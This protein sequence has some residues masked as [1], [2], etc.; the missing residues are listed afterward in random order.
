MRNVVGNR[1]LKGALPAAGDTYILKFGGVDAPL[2]TGSAGS[3]Y[4]MVQNVPKVI[5]GPN[6]SALV[7]LWLPA[8]S[9]A[10]SYLP[11]MAWVER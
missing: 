8:Q 9:A 1:F 6:E 3:L 2:L 4:T 11:E 7:Y 10:S 5:V